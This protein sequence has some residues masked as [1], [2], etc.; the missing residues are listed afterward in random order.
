M[1]QRSL[2][3]IYGNVVRLTWKKDSAL[4]V[5]PA[6]FRQKLQ[7]EGEL[8]Q[9]FLAVKP[10]EENVF[11]LRPGTTKSTSIPF[12]PEMETII[13]LLQDTL[14]K[15]VTSYPAQT[16]TG[17]PM[18]S[19]LKDSMLKPMMH[20]SDNFFAE[21]CLVMASKQVMKNNSL[22]KII[23]S[24]LKTSFSDLP[25]KP[26]WVDGSGLSRYN[27]FTP[28]SLVVILDKMQREFGMERLKVIF[29]AAEEGTLNNYYKGYS[30]RF[31]AK[32]G[33]LSGVVALSGYM[34]TSKNKLLIFSVL[35]NNHNGSATAVRRAV[36][37]FLV[38]IMEK[39]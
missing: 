15:Q 20:R 16:R 1:A 38:G 19:Q 24:V 21:Q 26:N 29:P 5:Q 17:I 3:P 37:K 31:F 10:W 28:A 12:R 32:T 39:E 22:N 33:T 23:D 2:L 11:T 30:S 25:Q 27:L 9:G 6:A 36:E 35:V 4:G 34:Y 14:D 13:Q 8:K 18:Y 7:M